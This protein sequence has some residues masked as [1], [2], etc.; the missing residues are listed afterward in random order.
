MG[1]QLGY[2]VEGCFIPL[3]ATF[4]ILGNL[5]SICVLRDN[6]LEMKATFREI[7][8]MLSIFDTIF[9]FSATISFSL[10]IISE[11]WKMFIH[12]FLLPWLLPILQISL[13]GSIWATVSVAIERFISIVHPRFWFSSFSS[14]VYIVPT[15]L[16]SVVWNIPRWNELYTCIKHRN[17]THDWATRAGPALL[18][19]TL[20]NSSAMEDK[21][22]SICATEFR[23][24]PDYIRYYI[25]LANFIVMAFLPFLILTIIN[26]MLYKTITNTSTTNKRSTNRQKRDQSIAMI[27]VGIVFVFAFC[28]V[29]RIIINLYEVFH[30]AIY[31]DIA[32]NWPKWC[33]LMSDFSH[34]LLV[35][36]SSVN[37]IIYGWKD[38][39][40]RELLLKLLNC[41]DCW[42]GSPALLTNTR[43]MTE[44]TV[45]GLDSNRRNKTS[46]SSL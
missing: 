43:E 39:K 10:P 8:I 2:V 5:A 9:A 45:L 31:G 16:L 6:R 23:D 42:R 34:L 14:T 26:S 38:A 36:N 32:K 19:H 22:F 27:L 29:F 11:H 24:D 15:L 40:F 37:I 46:E 25:L 41:H 4:G 18:L 35:L 7:L 17:D 3:V 13:N 12:P 1:D 30:L 44:V 21:N 33:S 28:N 20:T